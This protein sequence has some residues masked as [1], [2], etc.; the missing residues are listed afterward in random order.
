M[1][2]GKA[3]GGSITPTRHSCITACRNAKTRLRN[4]WRE[5]QVSTCSKYVKLNIHTVYESCATKTCRDLSRLLAEMQKHI[6]Q[7]IF[8]EKFK[9]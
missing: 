6:Y 1:L 8:D 9:F 2:N 4:I 3:G 7:K 5:I